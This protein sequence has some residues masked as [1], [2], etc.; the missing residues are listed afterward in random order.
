MIFG[1]GEHQ[2]SGQEKR[3]GVVRAER[4][5]K[6]SEHAFLDLVGL[7]AKLTVSM[8]LDQMNQQTP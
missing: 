1:G 2:T 5:S 4:V 3:R 8:S 6:M 7:E